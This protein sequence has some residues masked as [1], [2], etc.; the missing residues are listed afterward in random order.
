MYIQQ[1]IMAAVAY[2]ELQGQM[3]VQHPN[4][5]PMAGSSCHTFSCA[6]PAASLV[7]SFKHSFCGATKRKKDNLGSYS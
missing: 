7:S 3:H 5:H 6:L 2:R 4:L 1:P